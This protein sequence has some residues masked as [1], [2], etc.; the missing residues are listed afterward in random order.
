MT[1]AQTLLSHVGDLDCVRKQRHERTQQRWGAAP[2]SQGISPMERRVLEVRRLAQPDLTL[3]REGVVGAWVVLPPVSPGAGRSEHTCPGHRAVC[4]PAWDTA[5]PTY[6]CLGHGLPHPPHGLP[7]P[8]RPG[9][10]LPSHPERLSRR[11]LPRLAHRIGR[12]F[13]PRRPL[14][15][16]RGAR[17][18]LKESDAPY[19][20]ARAGVLR[21][22]PSWV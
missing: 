17:L 5:S 2:T 8:S 19:P 7:S 15:L 6:S 18:P 11:P 13:S 3:A 20:P 16:F 12:L 10:G 22:H 21:G 1:G 14:Y 4:V 9:P